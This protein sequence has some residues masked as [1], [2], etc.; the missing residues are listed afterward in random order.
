MVWRLTGVTVFVNYGPELTGICG[1]I[2]VGIVGVT[3]N[4][5]HFHIIRMD[6]RKS[7]QAI[8]SFYQSYHCTLPTFLQHAYHRIVIDTLRDSKYQ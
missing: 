2:D 1:F 6:S 7:V 4:T 8:K 3:I 5:T